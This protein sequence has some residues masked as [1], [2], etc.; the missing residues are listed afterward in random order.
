MTSPSASPLPVSL[1]TNEL[2]ACLEA[3]FKAVDSQKSAAPLDLTE[4]IRRMDEW[5][6]DKLSNAPAP[7]RHYLQSRSYRKAYLALGGKR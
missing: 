5:S 3:Y 1:E 2:M 7:V 4:P 6:T